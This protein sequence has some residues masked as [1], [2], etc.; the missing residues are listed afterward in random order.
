MFF[1]RTSGQR[2]PAENQLIQVHLK[3]VVEMEVTVVLVVVGS[4]YQASHLTD[5]LAVAD[6]WTESNFQTTYRWKKKNA[7]IVSSSWRVSI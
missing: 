4:T 2:K 5:G 6:R 7:S 1:P 3:K